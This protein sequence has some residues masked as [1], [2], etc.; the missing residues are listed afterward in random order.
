MR[1]FLTLADSNEALPKSSGYLPVPCDVSALFF[2]LTSIAML[3]LRDLYYLI[4]LG[5]QTPMRHFPT[6]ADI[7]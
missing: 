5:E 2:R 1:P 3:T 7:L 6:L 4:P